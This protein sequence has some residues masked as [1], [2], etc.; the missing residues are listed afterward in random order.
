MDIPHLAW[1]KISERIPFMPVWYAYKVKGIEEFKTCL[2]PEKV[3]EEADVWAALDTGN[4]HRV[5][6]EA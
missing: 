5:L 4:A 1:N 6:Y 2:G 3:I